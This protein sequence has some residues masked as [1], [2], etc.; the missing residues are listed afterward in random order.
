[1]WFF[2][3]NWHGL[4]EIES[5]PALLLFVHI[6]SYCLAWMHLVHS[7]WY[8][9]RADLYALN[10]TGNAEA[11]IEFHREAAATASPRL[12]RWFS[13]HPL[14]AERV[15]MARTWLNAAKLPAEAPVVQGI[16]VKAYGQAHSH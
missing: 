7:R 2:H 12:L 10:L 16:S 8:E 3:S 1:M 6:T 13:T 9:S 15:Q 5:L 14:A 4:G 11:M